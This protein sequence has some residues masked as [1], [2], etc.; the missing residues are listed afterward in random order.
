[1]MIRLLF[2]TFFAILNDTSAVHRFGLSGSSCMQVLISLLFLCR[3][4]MYIYPP[5]DFSGPFYK[6]HSLKVTIN[7][8]TTTLWSGFAVVYNELNIY[9]AFCRNGI[10]ND[11]CYTVGI[12][13]KTDH[14]KYRKMR[15][16]GY[17]RS[18]ITRVAM[19]TRDSHLE[20][21]YPD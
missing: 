2:E 21:L 7:S 1:M 4:S 3:N 5:N 17:L 9:L 16:R 12:Y 15:F 11:L 8:K 6:R 20:N 18:L 14:K 13:T 10:I 19:E